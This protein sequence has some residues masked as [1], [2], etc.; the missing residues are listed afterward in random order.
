MGRWLLLSLGLVVAVGGC[1]LPVGSDDGSDALEALQ[2]ARREGRAA[3]YLVVQDSGGVDS[4][5]RR[6][7]Q[8]ISFAPGLTVIS[9]NRRVVL[10]ER[11]DVSYLWRSGRRC[12]DR[13][14]EFEHGDLI[15]MRRD[16]VVAA[17][18]V[19]EAELVDSDHRTVVRWRG[20]IAERGYRVEGRLY[21]DR[22]GRPVLKRER[23]AWAGGRPYGPRYERRYRYP[24]R[25]DLGR[26]PGPRC[27]AAARGGR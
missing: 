21:L 13:H 26:P 20:P 8:R 23:T 6:L 7:R 3:R 2:A 16:I 27:R 14:T 9:R 19:D 1:D 25:L 22:V 17:A 11:R 4:A 18:L 12:Y 24:A 10:W 15:E 5:G